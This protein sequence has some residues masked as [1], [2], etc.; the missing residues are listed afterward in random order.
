MIIGI[1]GK[2]QSGKDT[3]GKIIQY[4][5]ANEDGKPCFKNKSFEEFIRVSEKNEFKTVYA[6]TW[7]IKKFAAKVKQILSLLTGISV[8]AMEDEEVKNSY[9]GEE[10]DLIQYWR[11]FKNSRN[12]IE[13]NIKYNNKIACDNNY[14]KNTYLTGKNKGITIG[15][16]HETVQLKNQITIR[17]ALQLIGT[18]LFRDKFHPNCWCNALFS[19]YKPQYIGGIDPITDNAPVHITEFYHNWLITDL[20][21]ENEAQAILDRQGIL[22]RV[23]RENPLIKIA[24]DGDTK[25]EEYVRTKFKKIENKIAHS[26]ETALDDYEGFHYTIE[27]NSSIEDLIEKVKDILIKEKLL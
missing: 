1:S 16:P 11:V 24:G 21:F 23:N 12:P 19:D 17:Q 8:G 13:P 27:N 22:I 26:S 6:G 2:A 4:L 14:S 10:W 3:V 9:L 7:Q 5:L 20:R 18:D 25:A 15:Y